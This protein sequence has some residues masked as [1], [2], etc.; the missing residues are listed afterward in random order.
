M[1]SSR[2]DNLHPYVPGEQPK[3]R[4][5]I[6]LNAN[7]NP[8]P[9]APEVIKAVSDF[10]KTH[11]ERLGL[12]PDP[13]SFVLRTAI[14]KMLN[15]TGGVLADCRSTGT[16]CE[17]AEKDMLPFTIT[18]EMIYCGNG[19]DEVLSFIFYAFFDSDRPLV[20]PEFTY[21]FYP[22][23]AGFYAVPL[24]P[25]PLNSDWTLDTKTMTGRAC[26]HDSGTIFANPNAPTG[27]MLSRDEVRQ[28]IQKS[29][30]DRVFVVDEAYADFGTESCI[31]LLAE[32]DNLVIVRTFSKSF[33]GAGLR[34][35]YIVAA[36]DIVKTVTTVKNSLNHFPVDAVTQ[37][38]GK[39][40]C[41]SVSYYVQC[42]K[43]I[44]EERE[45][46]SAFLKQKDWSVIPS[47]TN[48]IFT[49]PRAVSG[50][51]VYEHIKQNGILLRRFDTA[52]IEE[53]LRITIG[54]A[55]QMSVLCSALSNL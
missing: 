46:F 24:D 42:A 13:D 27:R 7:E 20:L 37:I 22:V 55:G 1:K 17:P 14:A 10:V 9:P 5:Y 47:C 6:K 53:Y 31:P 19:S 8:Y 45:K 54:T 11:P 44:V 32:F 21:S 18:P 52:G 15:R 33:C 23:Y 49:R 41:E 50:K 48:F 34:L 28:M 40:A 16:G 12:Y 2:M 30:K 38:A 36:P 26:A 39:A 4:A 43:K 25:V 51:K 35:G 3:D 29:P